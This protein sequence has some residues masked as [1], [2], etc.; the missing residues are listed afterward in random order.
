MD[1]RL[2]NIFRTT[3]RQAESTDTWMGIRREEPR[4][5]SRRK[6]GDDENKQE[7]PQWEDDTVVSIAALRQFLSTLIAPDSPLQQPTPEAAPQHHAPS[8]QQQRAHNAVNAYQNT[9][10]HAAPASVST[11]PPAT[12]PQTTHPTL[13]QDEN[14]TIHQLIHD[15]DILQQNGITSLTI[16]KEGSFLESLKQA[17]NKALLLVT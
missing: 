13:S 8:S 1:S 15:L 11:P 12:S 10:R 2:D 9:A 17:A 14:R 5:D 7:K 3:F 4:D 6:K 16:Q